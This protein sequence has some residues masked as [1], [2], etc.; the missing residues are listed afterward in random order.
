[1]IRISAIGL[2]LAFVTVFPRTGYGQNR[3]GLRVGVGGGYG[4][5]DASC[6][7]CEG[8][9]RESGGAVYV[10]AGWALSSRVLLGG[11]FRV[12]NGEAK[13][14]ARNVDA[15]LHLYNATATTTVFPRASSGLFV[16]GGLGA[17]FAD[18]EF[19]PGGTSIPGDRGTGV[20]VVAGAGYDV[21]LRGRVS[22]TPAVTVWFGR[23]GNLDVDRETFVGDWRHNVIEFTLGLTFQ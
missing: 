10:E 18:V 22:L 23:I 4:S 1:M 11:E 9:G 17:S 2:A 20:G 3:Q 13:G 8:S 12:W 6:D 14:I 16:K 19:K 5:A 7:E 15:G 21:P